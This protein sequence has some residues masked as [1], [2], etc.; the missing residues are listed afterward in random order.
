MK[1]APD[2]IVTR[3]QLAM[4]LYRYTEIFKGDTSFDDDVLDRYTDKDLISDYAV[5]AVKWAIS[6]GLISGMTDDTVGAGG[7]ATRAQVSVIIMKYY[8]SVK[9]TLKV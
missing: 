3:E 7:S 9:G 1:F 8:D 2:A 6:K 4:M 5:T